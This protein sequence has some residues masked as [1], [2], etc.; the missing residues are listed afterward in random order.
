MLLLG[1]IFFWPE[2]DE[3]KLQ[4]FENLAENQKEDKCPSMAEI[5]NVFKM[6]DLWKII[7]FIMMSWTFYTVFD[8]QLFPDFFTKFFSTPAI[9]H[10]AYGVLNSMEVFL[11]SIMM[12]LVPIMRRKTGVR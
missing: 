7:I 2:D 1:L 3:E 4:Q 12:G 10:Q 5:L 11:E 6:I 8:Q 9:G